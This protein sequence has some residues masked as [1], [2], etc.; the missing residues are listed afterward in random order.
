VDSKL[1]DIMVVVFNILTGTA[2]QLLFSVILTQFIY[3]RHVSKKLCKIVFVRTLSN[4]HH[5]WWYLADRR[6]RG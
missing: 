1:I 6:Q 5:F 2:R 3:L 4:F